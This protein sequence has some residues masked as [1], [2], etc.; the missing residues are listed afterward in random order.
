LALEK[1]SK[2]TL[3]FYAPRFE[4]EIQDKK[5]AANISK[6]ILNVEIDEKI[7]L[8][9]TFKFTM[10]DEFDLETQEFKWLDHPLFKEGNTVTIKMGYGA[11]L[12]TMIMGKI[13]K[14]EP[15][16]FSGEIPTLTISGHDLSYDYLKKERSGERTFVDKRYSDMA[17]TIA[18]EAGLL[19]V[20]DETG[21]SEPIVYRKDSDVSY[22]A[23]LEEIKTKAGCYQFDVD[24]KT[25]Y[26]IKP[27]D[28]RKE[29]LTLELKK[30]IISFSPTIKTTE[31]VTEV[32]VR[33]HN[34][35]DPK[36]PIIGR[37]ILGSEKIQEP[38]KKTGSQIAKERYGSVKRVITNVVVTSKEHADA[39]AKCE[40][41]KASDSLIEGDGE[42]IGIPQLRKGV[43][44]RLEK[45]GVRFS[46]KYYV[47]RTTHTLNDS[48][49]RTSFT[50]KRNAI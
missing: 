48:G 11:N 35:K 42:C 6:Q 21:K 15:S 24:G 29:I 25:M 32:E 43:N 46:G 28:D 34:P 10:N 38:G 8:G 16:F 41:N 36:T 47:K 1:I 7:D 31:L 13:T 12:N 22:Y 44:I 30:D 4:V 23:F 40:L 27:G 49:Y 19:A 3:N 17:R 9:A 2:E 26:F 39:I 50:V 37:A 18:S 45:M 5:L 33:G 20:V 14:I